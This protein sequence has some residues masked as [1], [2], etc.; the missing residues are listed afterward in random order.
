M[1][2]GDPSETDLLVGPP[3]IGKTQIN[4]T[5]CKECRI[6]LVAYTIDASLQEQV[7]SLRLFRKKSTVEERLSLRQYTM[8][9]IIAYLYDKI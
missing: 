3:G 4:R 7:R 2:S 6:G 8:S 1:D 5:G 9:E